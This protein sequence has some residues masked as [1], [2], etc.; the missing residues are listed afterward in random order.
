MT[1]SLPSLKIDLTHLRRTGDAYLLASCVLGA[2]LAIAVGAH[3]GPLALTS[4]CATV[5][6]GIAVALFMVA[7][8]SWLN[9]VALPL[10]MVSLVA[11]QIQ[12]AGGIVEYHFGVFVTLAGMLV[13]RHWLPIVVCAVGFAIH[14]VLFATLQHMGFP[15]FCTTTP[16]VPTVALHAGYVVFQAICELLLA[17]RMRIDAKLFAELSAITSSLEG[18]EGKINLRAL[19]AEVV[20]SGSQQLL[21]ALQ[22]IRQASSVAQSTAILVNHAATGIAEGNQTLSERTEMTA[23]DLQRTAAAVAQLTGTVANCA[24]TAATA[25]KVITEASNHATASEAAADQLEKR[26]TSMVETSRQVADITAVIDGIA[27]QTNILALNAAVEA[28][29]AGEAGRGFAVV[30]SEV[31]TLAQRSAAAS[32]EI[33]V[34]IAQS[35]E[36]VAVGVAVAAQ[37]RETMSGIITDVRRVH[38]L[39]SELSAATSEQNRGILEVNNAVVALDDATRKNACL[40]QQS[41]QSAAEFKGQALQ[42]RRALESFELPPAEG[43]VSVPA[44]QVR[45]SPST[46][47]TTASAEDWSTF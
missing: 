40:V 38:G 39:L 10:V 22:A 29:R 13:Y 27:F 46:G 17:R 21:G 6:C 3:Y 24:T 30:A 23:A 28:A 47:H 16:D 31:R 12:A 1:A 15:V 8:G 20:N 43:T 41:A 34:L 14:H 11:L 32:K 42:L 25:S 33:K 7:R 9:S 37:T 19:P 4:I 44:S 18:S 45:P 5:L 35:G 26:M 2:I 36:E